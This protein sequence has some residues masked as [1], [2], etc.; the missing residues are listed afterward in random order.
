MLQQEAAVV[1]EEVGEELWQQ[2]QFERAQALL[3]QITTADQ[4]VDFLT[5]PAYELLTA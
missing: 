2:Q 3:L 4:L 5:L 1:R